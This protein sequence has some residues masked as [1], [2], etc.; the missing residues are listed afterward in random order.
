MKQVM[1]DCKDISLD[2]YKSTHVMDVSQLLIFTRSVDN[3]FD[4]R[5]ELLKRV[6]SKKTDIFNAI[7]SVVNT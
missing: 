4:V 7:N 5:E 3:S 6:S 2:L 1:H